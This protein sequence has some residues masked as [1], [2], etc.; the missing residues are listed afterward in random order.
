MKPSELLEQR[1]QEVR[2]LGNVYPAYYHDEWGDFGYFE[3]QAR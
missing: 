2:E 1:E 3:G